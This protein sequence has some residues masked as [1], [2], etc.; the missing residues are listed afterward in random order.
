MFNFAKNLFKKSS[1]PAPVERS[2]GIKVQTDPTANLH[3]LDRMKLDRPQVRPPAKPKVT[4]HVTVSE[5]PNKHATGQ[6]VDLSP[7][8]GHP[9]DNLNYYH[10]E[11]KG[12]FVQ[13]G[14]ERK[15]SADGFSEA[16]AID[17]IALS[18]FDRESI[19]IHVADPEPATIDQ[20]QSM[21][22]HGDFIPDPM[23][24][25]DASYLIQRYIEDDS[26][27][28]KCLLDYATDKKIQIS[29]Y[30]GLNS[31]FYQ[32][33]SRLSREELMAV[34]LCHLS[35]DTK[36]DW[37]FSQF[38]VFIDLGRQLMDDPRFMKSWNEHHSFDHFK[39]L[40][41]EGQYRRRLYYTIPADKI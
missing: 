17:D 28:P 4:S 31:L 5:F 36:G 2:D 18:G 20:I 3:V 14:R 37:Q 26:A 16:D 27:A 12:I 32:F 8:T 24:K 10:Y 41:S 13:T 11:G 19:Q 7:R 23:C 35:F 39:G 38:D 9:K 1:A 40:C 33:R 21:K 29:Y 6:S 30:I 22:N 34:W 15:V 25:V